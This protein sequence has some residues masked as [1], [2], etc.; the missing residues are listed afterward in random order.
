MY[1]MVTAK[2]QISSHSPKAN[3]N[4]NYPL[5]HDHS[6][7]NC[8]HNFHSDNLVICRQSADF[9]NEGV[10]PIIMTDGYGIIILRDQEKYS[11]Y[12][13]KVKNGAALSFSYCY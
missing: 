2:N 7:F 10:K 11:L 1:K 13:S 9:T 6:L 3:V 5:D 12:L 4:A 8:N